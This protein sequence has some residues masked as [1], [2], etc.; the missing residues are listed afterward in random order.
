LLLFSTF[1]S[2]FSLQVL[3]ALRAFRYN[4]GYAQHFFLFSTCLLSLV[5][6]EAI[7]FL[8]NGVV[9]IQ[10]RFEQKLEPLQSIAIKKTTYSS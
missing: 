2:G 1:V 8:Y 10:E 7:P 3:A 5:T 9:I 6:I 4:P